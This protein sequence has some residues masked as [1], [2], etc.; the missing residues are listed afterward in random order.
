MSS[1]LKAGQFIIGDKTSTELK[2]V[3]QK[4]P[5]IIKPKRKISLRSIAGRSGDLI[6]DD[7]AY[8]NGTIELTAAVKGRNQEEQE[9]NRT[10]IGLAFDTGVYQTFVPYWDSKYEYQVVTISGPDFYGT[11]FLGFS[12]PYDVQL[13]FKPF[14][15]LRNVKTI[16]LTSSGTVTNPL[17]YDA[18][19]YIKITANGDVT[20]TVNGKN[21]VLKNIVDF[22]E[23]DSEIEEC[24]KLKNN[25]MTDENS[26]MY[27]IDFPVFKT[28]NNTISWSGDVTKIEIEPRWRTR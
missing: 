2:T 17:K 27:S 12:D 22:I 16:T 28:G 4:R 24:Y 14:K 26:K 1:E 11:R 20:L 23:L 3:I 15:K 7:E 5:T 8:E 13:S 25:V 6:V 9:Q 21:I 19:P 18:L 10:N